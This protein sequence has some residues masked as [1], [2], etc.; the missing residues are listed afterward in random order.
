M[1]RIYLIREVNCYLK[2]TGFESIWISNHQPDIG[3]YEKDSAKLI[4]PLPTDESDKY[5][6]RLRAVLE[7]AGI[8][9]VDEVV[10]DD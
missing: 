8:E 1:S 10:A 3:D 5:L 7:G 2:K 4:G 6:A 9:V